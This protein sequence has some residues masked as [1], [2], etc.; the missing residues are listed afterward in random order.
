MYKPTFIVTREPIKTIPLPL[1]AALSCK[2]QV[3]TA[4]PSALPSS[5]PYVLKL[6]FKTCPICE[7]VCHWFCLTPALLIG[8]EIAIA[9]HWY[10]IKLPHKIL[11]V[12]KRVISC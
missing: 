12:L 4:L 6:L 10:V 1:F 2:T 11:R 5:H 7:R 3:S 8:N 9:S